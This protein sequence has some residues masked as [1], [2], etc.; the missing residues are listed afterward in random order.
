MTFE[1][2]ESDGKPI[3]SWTRGVPVEEEA[4]Q[5]L[6]NLARLPFIHRH[7]AA[8]PDVH[9]GLGAT[10]G[11][12]IATNGAI[13]PAAVGV[14]IGC[15][16]MANRTTLD[17]ADLPDNLAGL[18]SQIERRIPHGRTDNGGAGERGAW[19]TAPDSP[20]L[21]S[22][23]DA[24]AVV[25][26]KHPKIA[27]AARR[28]PLHA[29]TLGTGN[30]FVESSRRF[31]T[32]IHQPRHAPRIRQ[33]R[34]TDARRGAVTAD[35]LLRN[36][37]ASTVHGPGDTP[38]VRRRQLARQDRHLRCRPHGAGGCAVSAQS[39]AAGRSG[40]R[41]EGCHKHGSGLTATRSVSPM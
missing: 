24:L 41:R 25:T 32:R 22:R 14:D 35:A 26:A 27:D 12:V 15:G 28:A 8:M 16:M 33:G 4:K 40:T 34:R 10:V 2:I 39:G 31:P 17:A 30:H 11:S 18:R 9:W 29:G 21:A 5:Q 38:S 7:V 37:P 19:G 3:K 1:I 36:G 23:M 6:R 20:E 13:I